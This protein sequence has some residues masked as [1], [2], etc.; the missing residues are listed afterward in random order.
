MNKIVLLCMGKKGYETIL[1][2]VN[3]FGNQ[4][5]RGIVVA[6]DKHIK[7]DYYTEIESLAKEN[8]IM[9]YD[10]DDEWED[11][12][13]DNYVFAISWRW[14]IHIETVKKVIIAHDSLLPRY[15]GFAPLVNMLINKETKLG[16]TFLFACDKYDAG[17]IILQKKLT[18]SYPI[19]IVEAIDLI[20]QKYS[21]GIIEIIRDIQ[22]NKNIEGKIQNHNKATFSLWRDEEDYLI[23]FNDSAENIQRFI[24]AV[25]YPYNGATAYL[26]DEKIRILDV[27]I[28][29]DVMIEDR[30]SHIGK[31][32]FL[33]NQKPV[34][35]CKQGLLKLENVISYQSGE[36][37]LPLNYFRTRFKGK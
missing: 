8:N 10:K 2:I 6:E 14:L 9:L 26:N 12:I 27:I 13:E 20:S 7:Y 15:R 18:V 11:I 5:I 19:K 31:V 3:T 16:V 17:N 4:I 34:I 35:I 24:D 25:G 37:I 23:N 21:E 32:I 30:D 36:S 28:Y 22:N 29:K 1:N 33:D